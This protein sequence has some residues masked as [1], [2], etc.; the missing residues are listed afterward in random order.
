VDRQGYVSN[1]NKFVEKGEFGIAK[2]TDGNVYIADGQVYVYDASGKF[3]KEIKT[4][5]R[6]TSVIVSND[7]KMM[8]I[9]GATSLYS[10][11]LD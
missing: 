8:Y 2:D 4:P 5:E 7:N 11:K 10:V 6:P 1:L 3:L 9:T